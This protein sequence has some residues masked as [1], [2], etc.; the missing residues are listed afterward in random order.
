M[1]KGIKGFQPGHEVSLTTR[2]KISIAL[3]GKRNSRIARQCRVCHKEFMIY[4]N[5][6]E[7]KIYCSRK[8]FHKMWEF[9]SHKNANKLL[10]R[11]AQKKEYLRHHK[12]ICAICGIDIIKSKNKSHL[13]HK[14]GNSKNGSKPNLII[15]CSPCHGKLHFFGKNINK[16]PI[17][18]I[19]SLYDAG[20]SYRKIGRI[21]G[22]CHDTIS[23]KL[24]TIIN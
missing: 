1:P 3:K 15:L 14:D 11:A 13:H 24:N 12:A 4:P 16:P 17:S 6:K 10:S 5:S 21:L 8:C 22:L 23:Y 18:K 19:I 7:K 9:I 2:R 20:Y